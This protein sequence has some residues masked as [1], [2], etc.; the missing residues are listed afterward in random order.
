[1][2]G[3]KLLIVDDEAPFVDTVSKRLIKRQV[4]VIIA[5][6]GQEALNKL[7]SEPDVV[8]VILDVKM[9]GMDGIETLKHIKSQYPLIE[10]IMLTGHAN[11][12]T[13]VEG[14]KYGAFDYL[15]KP[16][17]IDVLLA[18]CEEAMTKDLKTL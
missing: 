4:N 8:L 9:P 18:K 17:D 5:Y 10:V 12:E 11:V 14:I 15:M 7:K 2:F 16:C 6:S 1:M 3:G 13:A